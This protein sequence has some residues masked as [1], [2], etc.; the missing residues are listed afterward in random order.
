M[1]KVNGLVGSTRKKVAQL[2]CLK[3]AALALSLLTEARRRDLHVRMGPDLIEAGTDIGG[4]SFL[5]LGFEACRQSMERPAI[6]RPAA[7]IHAIHRLRLGKLT[8]VDQEGAERVPYRHD[9]VRRFAVTQF[10]FLRDRRP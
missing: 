9:P 10:V 8:I 3:R 2:V 6:V 7:E 5:A 4:L 1:G